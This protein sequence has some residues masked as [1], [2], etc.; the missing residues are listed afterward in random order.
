MCKHTCIVNLSRLEQ[1][2]DNHIQVASVSVCNLNFYRVIF[3]EVCRRMVVEGNVQMML[4]MFY[5][6]QQVSGQL[7]DK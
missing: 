4:S 7:K 3:V 6:T 5:P 2:V 1:E